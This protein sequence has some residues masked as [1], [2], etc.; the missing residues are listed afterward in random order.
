MNKLLEKLSKVGAIKE[1]AILSESPF[2]TKRDMITTDL[3]ILNVAFSGTLDGGLVPGLTILAGA[4]KSFKTMLG[5][6]CM[7]A[8]F[9]KY[10]DAVCLFYDTEFGTP[11]SY[12]QSMN[13]DTSRVL[14]IPVEH[15]E[16]LKFDI[17]KRLSEI[18]RKDKVFIMVDSLGNLA[19]KKEVEDAADEKSVADMSRAKAIR[20][21]LRIITPHLTT[22]DIPCIIINHVYQTMEMFSKVVIPGGT[23]V[24]YAANQIFVISKSQEKN[25]S[26]E[27]DGYK[28]TINIE[29][30]RYVREK[31]KLPFTVKYKQGINKWS[32][33]LELALEGNYVVKPKVGWYSVVDR[34][35]GEIN[36]KNYREKDI[37]SNDEIW[38]NII[39]NTDFP[40]FVKNKFILNFDKIEDIEIEQEVNDDE[41]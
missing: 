7:K 31:S 38:N 3:P 1:S 40:E 14:H 11:P 8:Y 21:L 30:S 33:L 2:F 41:E 35:T 5:L 6:Y 20:S 25:S 23:A 16:Q 34:T 27:L 28:F 12:L 10:P 29:K 36:A 4:S 22:K 24:T 26:G 18:D 19:S 15:V 32:G 9:N 37:I 17:V 39:N 13:I